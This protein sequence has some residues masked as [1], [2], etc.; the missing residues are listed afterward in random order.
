MD[1]SFRYERGS[2]MIQGAK[3]VLK[4]SSARE[5]RGDFTWFSGSA[6]HHFF[7]KETQVE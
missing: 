2:A 1:A 4:G 7:A 6:L 3:R 5:R